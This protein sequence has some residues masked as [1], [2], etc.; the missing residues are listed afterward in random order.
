MKFSTNF[1]KRRRLDTF[2]DSIFLCEID[3]N[4]LLDVDKA[5]EASDEAIDALTEAKSKGNTF[6]NLPKALFRRRKI[7]NA[8]ENGTIP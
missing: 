2:R 6:E 7:A 8:L 5:L 1:K 3:P 4:V